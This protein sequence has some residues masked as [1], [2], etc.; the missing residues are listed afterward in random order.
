MVCKINPAIVGHPLIA[1]GPNNLLNIMLVILYVY[2]FTTNRKI[3]AENKVMYH[4]SELE[5]IIL[6]INKKMKY[7]Y[8]LYISLL[9]KSNKLTKY[10]SSYETVPISSRKL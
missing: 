6:L 5:A 7:V 8:S 9:F 3:N 2:G 10:E 4:F 1:I